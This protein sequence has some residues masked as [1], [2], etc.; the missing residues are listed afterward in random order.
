MRKVLLLPMLVAGLYI[1]SCSGKKDETGPVFSGPQTPQDKGWAFEATPSWSDE[2]DYTGAP[3]PAKWDYDIGGSGWGNNEL[4]YYT[5]ATDNAVVGN[6]VLTITARK[7]AMG[8]RDYTSARLVT[9]KRAISCTAGSRSKRNS[10]AAKA[11]GPRS[12]CCPPIGLMATGR[13]PAKS[14]SWNM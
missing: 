6:G 10:R 13:S 5:N 14:T 2:F 12:G 1:L 3:D 4:Q 7:Q 9:R 8:G 11:P